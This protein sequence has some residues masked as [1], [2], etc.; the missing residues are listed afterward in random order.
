MLGVV[1]TPNVNTGVV[2]V[3]VSK[4]SVEIVG[5]VTKVVVALLGKVVF[6]VR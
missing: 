4:M 5:V 6:V 1:E 2:V 3:V